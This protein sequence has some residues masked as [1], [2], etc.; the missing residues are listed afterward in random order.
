MKLGTNCHRGIKGLGSE[1]IN[2]EWFDNF[3][4]A[5]IKINIIKNTQK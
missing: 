5:N 2:G 3:L 4:S 1:V